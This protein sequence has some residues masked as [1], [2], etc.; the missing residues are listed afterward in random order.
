MNTFST[1]TGTLAFDVTEV[2]PV[3][4]S[5]TINGSPDATLVFEPGIHT[6][7]QITCFHNNEPMELE[8]QDNQLTMRSG[9]GS[10]SR[11]FRYNCTA[12]AGSGRYYWYSVDWVN[13]AVEE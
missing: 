5:G 8:I 13:T 12:P 9:A 1:R 11:R 10:S 2:L 6:L 4:R 7:S 3:E